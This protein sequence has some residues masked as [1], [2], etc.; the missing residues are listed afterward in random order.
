MS[1]EFHEVIGMCTFLGVTCEKRVTR[2]TRVTHWQKKP[3]IT[4]QNG[5]A[6][7]RTGSATASPPRH[8]RVT[9]R[10]SKSGFT[11]EEQPKY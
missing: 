1:P 10:Q 11:T 3:A 6:Y 4:G 5:I 8:H 7:T 9:V 2:V